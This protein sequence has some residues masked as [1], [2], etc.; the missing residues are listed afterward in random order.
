MR[1]ETFETGLSYSILIMIKTDL[2]NLGVKDNFSFQVFFSGTLKVHNGPG[3]RPSCQKQLT[4]SFR[5][6]DLRMLDNPLF[7]IIFNPSNIQITLEDSRP[8]LRIPAAKSKWKAG[9]RLIIGPVDHV[10]S[11]EVVFEQ[12]T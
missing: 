12:D 1:S 7:L 6:H 9:K 10:K 11:W 8:V 2:Y 3:Y 4:L 5:H